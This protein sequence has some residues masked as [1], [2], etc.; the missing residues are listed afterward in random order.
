MSRRGRSRNDRFAYRWRHNTEKSAASISSVLPWSCCPALA[1]AAFVFEIVLTAALIVNACYSI[2]VQRKMSVARM[3]ETSQ[4]QTIEQIGKLRGGR[5]QRAALEKMEKRE[6]AQSVFADVERTLFWIMIC[7][8]G[9]YAIAAFSLFAIAKLMDSPE[10][11]RADEPFPHELDTEKRASGKRSMLDAAP[12]KPTTHVSL[13]SD[14]TD[15]HR[16]TTQDDTGEGL[17]RLRECLKIVAFEHGP[18]HFKVD[19]K[20]DAGYVWIRQMRSEHGEARM[21]ASTKA[22]LAILSDAVRMAPE[23]FRARLENF[24][25]ENEFEI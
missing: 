12:Q 15:A 4:A 25:R 6:T 17:R 5:T 11:A 21:V 23:A 3:G 16:K 24:L 19:V 22:A 2:S 8:L 10:P 20:P 14:D 13:K 1:R 7:E 18:T 9:L